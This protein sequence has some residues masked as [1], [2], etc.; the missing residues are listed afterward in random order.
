MSFESV[1]FII[2]FIL[3]IIFAQE[4]FLVIFPDLDDNDVMI[5]FIL[6]RFS[7]NAE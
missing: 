1:R 7:M 4:R 3:K 2:I 6:K 5:I